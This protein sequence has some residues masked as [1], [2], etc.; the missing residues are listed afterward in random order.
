[1]NVKEIAIELL[2][3][4]LAL[5]VAL[6]IGSENARSANEILKMVKTLDDAD[7]FDCD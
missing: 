4:R 1:M 7:K 6:I 2:L 5:E 3:K